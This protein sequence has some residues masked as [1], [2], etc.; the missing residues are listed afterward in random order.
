MT[1]NTDHVRVD[2]HGRLVPAYK[3]YT[4][5]GITWA[6][7]IGSILAG[8]ILMAINYDRLGQSSA[9]WRAVLWSALTTAVLLGIAATLPE[10]LSIPNSLFILPQVIIM[11]IAARLLQGDAI[12]E[13]EASGGSLTS[14]WRAIG[15]GFLCGV[16]IMA[17][18]F[19]IAYA[20]TI[21]EYGTQVKLNDNDEVY[22]SGEATEEDARF[23]GDIL[24]EYE[25]FGSA[26]GATV[27][28]AASKGHY[29]ISFV[30][31]EGWEETGVIWLFRQIGGDL[32]D[33]RFGRPLTIDLCNEYLESQRSISI[34]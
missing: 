31:V 13:H 27:R 8:G 23:L 12:E 1:L 24:T 17:V 3:L 4:V 19:G 20:V 22:Y 10:S 15:V 2:D 29:T 6:T 28:I 26:D 18:I 34:E 7:F 25:Y 5:K 9:K 33:A 11:G 32:A 21:N 16:F 14:V 30:L